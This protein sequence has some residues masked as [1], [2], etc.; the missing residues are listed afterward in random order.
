MPTE[1]WECR[2]HDHVI[3][4]EC[5]WDWVQWWRERLFIDGC[6]AA[7]NRGSQLLRKPSR[8]GQLMGVIRHDGIDHSVCVL[9][10]PSRLGFPL[11]CGVW[12]GH[13]QLL[14]C[15]HIFDRRN[16]RTSLS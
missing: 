4:V 6:L 1:L 3:R 15:D 8:S 14:P 16:K 10:G 11:Q 12:V 7:E 2:W 5:H 9:L 13:E